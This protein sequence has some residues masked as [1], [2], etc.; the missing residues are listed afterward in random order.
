[1]NHFFLF[2]PQRIACLVRLAD[3]RTWRCGLFPR[4]SML[5]IAIDSEKYSVRQCIDSR[6]IS[7]RSISTEDGLDYFTY[8][9]KIVCTYAMTALS[10]VGVV[11][12]LSD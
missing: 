6:P 9:Y 11:S 7:S 3:R 1:M 12:F 4:F 8:R 5:V 2:D 10:L